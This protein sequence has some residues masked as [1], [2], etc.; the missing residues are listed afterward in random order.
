MIDG[1]GT[2]SSAAGTSSTSAQISA[3]SAGVVGKD[4]F[5]KMLIAQIKYQD[6]LNP[7]DGAAFA[8]QLAQFS[9]LEQLTSLNETLAAQSTSYSQLMNLQSVGLIGKE[10]EANAIDPETSASVT[11]TGEVTAVQ[12]RDNAIY[13]TVNDQEVAFDNL[14]SVK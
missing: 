10:V 8:A 1:V 3:E 12:F 5:F 14:V 11:V 7:Q 13:L 9:S 2:A 4:D 6:P